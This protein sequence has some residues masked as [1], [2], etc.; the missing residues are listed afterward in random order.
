[1]IF[2]LFVALLR[3]LRRFFERCF[4]FF[5]LRAYHW[6][7]VHRLRKHFLFTDWPD[8]IVLL[9]RLIPVHF[10]FRVDHNL[11]F[12]TFFWLVS[13]LSIASFFYLS[14]FSVFSLLRDWQIVLKPVDSHDF[15]DHL[16]AYCVWNIVVRLIVHIGVAAA[17]TV[18][19][20][21]Q[22]SLIFALATHVQEDALKLVLAL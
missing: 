20:V 12:F 16:V 18:W 1:M 7:L 15:L 8:Y 5:L 9:H 17:Y 6:N 11:S 21:D 10:I 4:L 19:Q 3:R 13:H 14:A 22:H 2:H